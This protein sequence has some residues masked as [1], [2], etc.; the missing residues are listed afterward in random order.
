MIGFFADTGIIHKA[1][2]PYT[3]MYARM[4]FPAGSVS[5]DAALPSFPPAYAFLSFVTSGP[6]GYANGV[7]TGETPPEM[8]PVPEPSEY[9]PVGA[10]MLVALTAFRKFKKQREAA[11]HTLRPAVR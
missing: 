2:E 4:I 10:L 5:Y 6:N 8:S 7:S 11:G 1:G 9:G 3:A